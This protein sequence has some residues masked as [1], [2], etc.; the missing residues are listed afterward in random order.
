MSRPFPT[1]AA[2]VRW[3]TAAGVW[4]PKMTYSENMTRCAD[5]RAKLGRIGGDP[6]KTWARDLVARYRA[7]EAVQVYSIRLAMEALD[8]PPETILRT[9]RTPRTPVPR[10]DSKERAA[11][12][13]EVAF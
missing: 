6:G 8:L 3:L 2:A 10:P 12:D 13:V 11:G 5:Y 1:D 4:V 9:P 7:G